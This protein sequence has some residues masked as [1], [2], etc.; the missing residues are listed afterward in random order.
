ME[1]VACK[2]TCCTLELSKINPCRGI[3]LIYLNDINEGKLK[4]GNYYL[5]YIKK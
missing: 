2:A 4:L 5:L 3:L 1:N